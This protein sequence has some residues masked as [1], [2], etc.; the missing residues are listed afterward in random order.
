MP[1]SVVQSSIM[2][3]Q[4]AQYSLAQVEQ[5]RENACSSSSRWTPAALPASEYNSR[6][7]AAAELPSSHCRNNRTS[8]QHVVWF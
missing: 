1:H 8:V 3:H 2:K 5:A 4:C 6:P 7:A